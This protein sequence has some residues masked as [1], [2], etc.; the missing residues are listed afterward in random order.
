MTQRIAAFQLLFKQLMTFILFSFCASFTFAGTYD[1]TRYPVILLHGFLG[2]EHLLGS[3]Y[4]YSIPDALRQEGAVVYAPTRSAV[5]STEVR[6]E[7]TIAFLENLRQQHGYTKFNLIG[8][9]H[10][11][12]DAR[13][14]MA[15]H[16]D[17]VASVTTIGTPND[18]AFPSDYALANP[19]TSVLDWMYEL[20]GGI[21]NTLDGHNL[22]QDKQAYLNSTSTVG[23]RAFNQIY[24]KGVVNNC[25]SQTT[26]YNDGHYLYSMGGT[27]VLTNGFDITDPWMFAQ[28]LLS[29]Q[30]N[31]G[32][33]NR[34]STH[35]GY[36]LQDDIQWNHLDEVNQTNGLVG[37]SA[38]NP[39][40]VYKT[41]VNRLKNIG[42]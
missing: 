12:I 35:F 19:W 2:S 42:L 40:I 38:P 7:Q 23:I 18:G 20:V 37:L 34:C 8:H 5:N 29:S 27:A 33:I 6:G 21:S 14:V 1:Q 31:D 3:D 22:P 13:Y 36:V 41:H 10:G 11:G 24:P 17:W 30:P 16:P 28:S 26:P 9:S 4:F 15:K 25:G 32:W 39:I